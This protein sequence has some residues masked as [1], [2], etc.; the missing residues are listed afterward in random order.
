[1][2]EATTASEIPENQRQ[3]P[4]ALAC[5]GRTEN[6]RF[7]RFEVLTEPKIDHA[8]PFPV[9]PEPKSTTSTLSRF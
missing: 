2:S 6:S 8:Q 9:L 3:P 5:S 4:A 1:M 7:G